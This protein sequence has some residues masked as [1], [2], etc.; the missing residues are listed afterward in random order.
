MLP[1]QYRLPASVRLVNPYTYSNFFFLVKFAPNELPLNRYGFIIG[2]AVAKEATERNRAR[3]LFRSCVEERFEE[4]KVGHDMLFLLK[5]GII[6]VEREKLLGE[7][8]K[9]LTEKKLR[10]SRIQ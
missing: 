7:L 10:I 5:K 9:F 4:I 2:K 1:R 3:R 8:D 6:G